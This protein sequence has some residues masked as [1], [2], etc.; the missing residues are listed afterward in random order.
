MSAYRAAT[1]AASVGVALYPSDGGDA[2]TLLRN[3]DLAM[4]R[5]QGA[6]TH[7]SV[8]DADAALS[9]PDFRAAERVYQLIVQVIGRAGRRTSDSTA[10]IQAATREKIEFFSP[11][12]WARLV[13]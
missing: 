9:L 6:K 13:K 5:R 4:Y 10:L 1:A 12:L 11:N 8:I 2:T 3:A 7:R